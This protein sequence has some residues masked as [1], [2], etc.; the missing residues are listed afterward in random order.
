MLLCERT[1]EWL[2]ACRERPR[3]FFTLWAVGIIGAFQAHPAL[4][5][6]G[7]VTVL[8]LQGWKRCPQPDY[9]AV[10]DA[11]RVTAFFQKLRFAV[12]SP[13]IAPYSVLGFGC[14]LFL[15]LLLF[16]PKA[17]LFRFA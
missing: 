7:Y 11:R 4:E 14:S 6:R 1:T 2:W 12:R 5:R 8:E 10:A 16:L 13:G 9:F 3:F 17:L 15:S